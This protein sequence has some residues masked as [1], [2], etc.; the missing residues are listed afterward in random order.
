M[1]NCGREYDWKKNAREI[2]V[3]VISSDCVPLL[4]GVLIR[5]T[6]CL[7]WVDPGG[8]GA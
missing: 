5:G 2:R 6:C 7:E 3:V 4:V 1:K 8:G